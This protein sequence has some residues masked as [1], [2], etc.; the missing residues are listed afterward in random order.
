ME[1][2]EIK[3]KR[4]VTSR[5]PTGIPGFDEMVEGGFERNSVVLVAGGCGTG[6][7]T[8][9]MQFLYE[10]AKRGEHGL[11]ISLE[12][13]PEKIKRYMM[14][15]GW[16]LNELEYNGEL[17]IIRIPPED[18]LHVIKEQFS[19]IEDVMREMNAK[20][21]VIDS[22]STLH[23]LIP[24]SGERRKSVFKLCEWLEERDCT[25][26]IIE[27]SHGGFGD[28]TTSPIEFLMDGVVKIYNIRKDAMRERAIEVLKM[29]GTDHMTKLAPF[30][31]ERGI[32]VF[33][34]ERIF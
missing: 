2:D 21:V 14:R 29:R 11:Y 1:S 6:K 12:E 19:V 5:I 18:I 25:S 34:K 23:L 7:S 22:I 26:L 32:K 3:A 13:R 4:S 20:R 27:E 28:E 16:D 31:F 24:D 17:K 30:K 10:G 15:Y 8:F 9:C 33:P